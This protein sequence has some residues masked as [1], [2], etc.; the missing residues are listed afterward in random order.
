MSDRAGIDPVVTAVCPD[1]MESG[2]PRHVD[3]GAQPLSETT[4]RHQPLHRGS[5]PSPEDDLSPKKQY[6]GPVKTLP[7]RRLQDNG[8][9]SQALQTTTKT[10][11]L[12]H[13]RQN[14]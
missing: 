6:E 7:P 1:E 4:V 9:T 2:K 11:S 3:E 8:E 14:Q 10:G 5:P 13:S 12:Q